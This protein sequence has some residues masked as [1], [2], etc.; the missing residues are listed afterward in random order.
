F[1]MYLSFVPKALSIVLTVERM[2]SSPPYKTLGSKFPCK[3]TLPFVMFLAY[4]GSTVQCNEIVSYPIF[5]NDS[6]AYHE[7]LQNIVIGTG[8]SSS[9]LSRFLTLS[10][11]SVI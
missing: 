5:D 4:V 8:V 7:P 10:A 3:V 2:A 6:N 9:S 1:T 11:I